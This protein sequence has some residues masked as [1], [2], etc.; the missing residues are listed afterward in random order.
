[1]A[2]FGWDYPP[3]VTGNEL[4]IARPDYEKETDEPCPDCGGPALEVGHHQR[5]RWLACINYD[6]TTDLPDDDGDD[7]DRKYDEERDRQMIED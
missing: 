6:H 4:E 7:P 5:G 1:M 3:G 2:N